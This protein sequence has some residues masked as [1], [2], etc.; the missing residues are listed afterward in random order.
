[1]IASVEPPDYSLLV[2]IDYTH[3]PAVPTPDYVGLDVI[4]SLG[5][6]ISEIE[7]KGFEVEEEVTIRGTDLH[8]SNLTVRLGNVELPVTMQ[9][10]DELRFIVSP[11]LVNGAT[12]SAG[13]H[14]VSL[15]Q[16]LPSGK[17]RTSN[18]V[19]ANLVPTL[20]PAT[21]VPPD[22]STP[23]EVFA[24]IDFDGILL[25]NEDDDVIFAF[26]RNGRVVKMFDNSELLASP[27][28]QTQRRLIIISSEDDPN[29]M[30][31]G[32]YLVIL[33]VNGQ[34]AP[35]SPLVNLIL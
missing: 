30:P 14:P 19:I 27:Q 13:S 23:E 22:A 34:Q 20:N 31:E 15:V 16:T 12:I 18:M 25:G 2:G 9:R 6:F 29:P 8:L 1:M 10:P 33:R 24:T 7:P 17:K 21:I 4:P 11:A 26:Y 3:T 5:S 35:Q 28:P 32:E